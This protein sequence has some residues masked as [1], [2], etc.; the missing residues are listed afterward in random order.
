MVSKFHG[1]RHKTDVTNLPPGV[2]TVGSQNVVMNDGERV[3]IRQGYSLF[4]AAS[5]AMTPIVSAFDW[6]THLGTEMHSRSFYDTLQFL[7]YDPTTG[8]PIWEN[9]MTGFGAL[10][11]FKYVGFWNTTEQSDELLF[12]NGSS[13]IYEWSGGITTF[14]S[15]TSNTITKQGTQTWGELGFFTTGTR[16]VTIAGVDYTYTGGEGTTTLTDVS[17]DPTGAGIPVGA[18]VFQTVRVHANSAST[19][20]PSAFANDGI[21]ILYNQV[22]I[23]SL[24]SRLVFVSKV[25]S[26]TD[27]SFAVPRVVGQGALFTLDSNW[28]G[29]IPQEDSMYITAGLSDWYDTTFTLSSDNK[30]EAL[31]VQRLKT[32]GQAAAQSQSL[33]AKIKNYVFFVSN[34]PSLDTLGKIELIDTPQSLNLSDP[35]KLDFDNYNFTG[36]QC[37]YAKNYIYL[38]IPAEGRVLMFSMARGLLASQSATTLSST[39]SL[40]AWEAPQI[41]PISCFSLING[42]LYGHSSQVPETYLLFDGGYNDNGNPI[43]ARAAFSYQNEGTRVDQKIFS[44]FYNEG[45]IQSNT[46]LMGSILLNYFGCEGTITFT[47]D[48]SDKNTICAASDDGSLGKQTLGERSLAGRGATIDESIPPKY[49]IIKTFNPSQCFE[50]QIVYSTNDVDQR[51]ELLA[52]GPGSSLSTSTNA[53][54]TE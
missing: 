27:Y 10:V 51:W 53:N 39:G 47:I 17:P 25:D 38:A 7:Y 29:F 42:L 45:Y 35:I 52:F 50:W 1:Y 14:A 5:A 4:G 30:S 37:F 3:A 28:V 41:L 13:N 46:K 6:Q 11:N 34:E 9:L 33:I 54:I 20:L 23:G 36:G 12:V 21:A 2:I 8:A 40:E 26:F 31:S 24:T 48:G 19:G 44:E 18:L 16:K 22:Y 49:R 32:T 15:A 43:D